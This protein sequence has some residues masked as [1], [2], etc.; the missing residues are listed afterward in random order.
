M[1]V[2]V[3][4]VRRVNFINFFLSQGKLVILFGNLFPL[5]VTFGL[6]ESFI[7]FD[8][9]SFGDDFLMNFFIIKL[10]DL[11]YPNI[12]INY[13]LF[14]CVEQILK[15]VDKKVHSILIPQFSLTQKLLV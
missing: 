5:I 3:V 6:G 12:L 1:N 4:V 13:F 2:I 10:H 8:D 9:F 7:N 14:E 15:R 11:L